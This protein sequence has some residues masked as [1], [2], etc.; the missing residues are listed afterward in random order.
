MRDFF[1]MGRVPPAFSPQQSFAPESDVKFWAPVEKTEDPSLLQDYDAFDRKPECPKIKK[2]KKNL[3]KILLELIPTLAPDV[4]MYDNSS[5]I[6]GAGPLA[7]DDENGGGF[8]FDTG[9]GVPGGA[10]SSNTGG[11]LL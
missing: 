10:G 9:G 4:G 7:G 11:L 3:R 8:V 6:R 2:R 5:G 1:D